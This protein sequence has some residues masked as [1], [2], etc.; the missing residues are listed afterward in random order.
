MRDLWKGLT[1]LAIDTQLLK[2]VTESAKFDFKPDHPENLQNQPNVSALRKID[3]LYRSRG[4]YLGVYALAEVN[5]WVLDG[6][7]QFTAA[8]EAFREALSSSLQIGGNIQ[9]PGFLEAIGALVSDPLLRDLFGKNE[10]SLHNNGFQISPEEEEALRADFLPGGKA[11]ALADTI[12]RLGWSG[13]SCESRF[14]PYA[15]MFHVNI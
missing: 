3:G 6:G 15:G 8:L 5:R 4:V 14:L 13:S 12:F 1:L 7:T 10:Q 9:S 11:D 2:E